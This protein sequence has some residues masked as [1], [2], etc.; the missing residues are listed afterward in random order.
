M[1]KSQPQWGR[2]AQQL[3]I[4]QEWGIRVPSFFVLNRDQIAHAESEKTL[5]D[6]LKSTFPN[7]PPQ[8]FAV[9]SSAQGED[10]EKE[11]MAGAFHTELGVSQDQ[12]L[13]A[14]GKVLSS[15]KSSNTEDTVIV[16][17]F[18]PSDHAGVLFTDAGDGTCIVN[19]TFGLCENAVRGFAVDEYI[20]DKRGE[21]ISHSI[22]KKKICQVFSHGTIEEKI[23]ESEE[24]VLNDQEL[25]MLFDLGKRIEALSGSPQDIEWC[26]L[27][28][29]LFVLQSRPITRV[30][31]QE[32]VF[33]DSANIAESYS[34]IVQPLTFSFAQDI[35]KH[36][37]QNLLTASGVSPKVIQSH[38]DIFENMI[39]HIYGRMYYNMNNWYR[40]MAFL[41]GYDRNKANLEQMISS[42][43]REEVS[44]TIQPSKWLRFKYPFLVLWKLLWFGKTVRGFER[45]VKSLLKKAMQQLQLQ[46]DMND[47]ERVYR[48]LHRRLLSRWHIT[49]ENDFLVMTFLGILKHKIKSEEALIARV[50]FENV[51]ASQVR[52]LAILG[53]EVFSDAKRQLLFRERNFEGLW[54]SIKKDRTLADT[55]E[56]Y[57]DQ[58]G[59]R[60][61]NELKLESPDLQEDNALL[62]SLLHRY[63]HIDAISGRQS[64]PMQRQDDSFVLRWMIRSFRKAA[65]K[66]EDL[67]LLRSQAFGIVRRIFRCLG[68][69]LAS[70]RRIEQSADVFYLT[71]E[72]AFSLAR[73]ALKPHE[74]QSHIQ[75][76]KKAFAEY[77]P[78]KLQSHFSRRGQPTYPDISQDSVPQTAYPVMTGR[79][80]TPGSVTGKVRLFPSFSMPEESFDILVAERTDP[81][82]TPLIGLSKGMIVEHGGLLSHAAIVARE[83]GIPTVIGVEG[84]LSRLRSGQTVTI[85]GAKGTVTIYS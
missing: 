8:Y 42:N 60:F 65:S 55:M 66:R 48:E 67:R 68:E 19:A 14:A 54:E 62:F 32:E 6:F 70:E 83:L 17:E 13:P 18:I 56:R 38:P 39:G 69:Q 51:S 2:K 22:A 81:G 1:P 31:R 75:N 11:S 45:D 78:L 12:I 74:A 23:I 63:E 64:N 50:H 76:R 73:G 27:G 59:G 77:A 61:A 5:H 79:G 80:S 47:L 25:R 28:D 21:I 30:I 40:M 36:V 72:E 37:Y 58:Y 71:V 35:Y 85:D 9:R 33:Y 4:L 82:W 57:F 34:G 15:Y 52:S 41:P 26:F 16:Q 20:L 43:V 84:A 10:S 29:T 7:R 24:A 46:P 3:S 49:V 44:H 53:H